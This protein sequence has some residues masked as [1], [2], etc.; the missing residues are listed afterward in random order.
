MYQNER[1][2]S[3]TELVRQ[4][5]YVTVKYLA[6]VLHYSTATINRDLN[7]LEGRGVLKRTYGG[8]EITDKHTYVPLPFRY[9]QSRSEKLKLDKKAAELIGDGETVFIDAGTT[10][11][12]IGQFLAEKK[13]LPVITNNIALAARISEMK[14]RTIVLGGEIIEPPAMIWSAETTEAV[15]K[16]RADKLFFSSSSATKNG[17]V[18]FR[19]NAAMPLMAAMMKQSKK[20]YF[21][22]DGDKLTGD[23]KSGIYFFCDFSSCTGVISDY[24]FS[25][26]VKAAFPDTEFIEV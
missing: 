3:I 6:S 13:D 15:L 12:H 20:T 18:Y 7:A 2:E 24:A 11:E 10:T 9:H 17:E 16:Y 5:G 1:L 8:V 26:E 21:L 22:V 25:P 4:Y 14:I 19:E 23:P